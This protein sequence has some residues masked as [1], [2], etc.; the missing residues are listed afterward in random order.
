ML[1][2]QH[3]PFTVLKRNKEGIKPILG[4]EGLQQHLPFTVLKLSGP[5]TAINLFFLMVATA[6]TV[7]GIETQLELRV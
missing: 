4:Y 6:L 3:L 5:A 1:L 2:Q 7:H